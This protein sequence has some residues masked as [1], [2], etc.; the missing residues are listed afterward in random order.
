M[1]SKL[2]APGRALNDPQLVE[3]VHGIMQSISLEGML[4]DLA[5]MKSR[6][7]SRPLLSSI[8]IPV[9]V[10]HGEDDQ[11]VP[12]QEAREMSSAIPGARLEVIPSAGHLL[13]LEQPE[14]F[15]AHLTDFLIHL[16]METER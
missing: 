14:A 16:P 12:L 15:N 1:V 7:N 9:L 10:L 11:I 13:N 4:G 5:G 6:P 2:L 3:Q 8:D